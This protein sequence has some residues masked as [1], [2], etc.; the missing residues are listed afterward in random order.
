MKILHDDR[1]Y[2]I[3]LAFLTITGL[4]L[5]FYSIDS[6]SIWLDEAITWNIS[7]LPVPVIWQAVM[8]DNN[9]PLF[10]FIEHIMLQF[11]N[12][13]LIL[14]LIPAIAGSMT[15]PAFY[16]LGKEFHSRGIGV[17]AAALLAFSSYHLF[18]S[19]EARAYSVLLLIFSI[20]LIFYFKAFQTNSLQH[21]MLCGFFSAV[22]CWLH[23]T[24]FPVIIFLFLF[25]VARMVYKEHGGFST[26]KPVIL[27]ATFSLII[28]APMIILA[29]HSL[30]SKLSSPLTW[31]FKGY[32]LITEIFQQFL[33]NIFGKNEIIVVIL[34]LL[35]LIGLYQLYRTDR[36]KFLF[37]FLGIAIPILAGYFLSTKMPTDPRY[38][39]LI[40]P[41][42]FLAI[43]VCLISFQ[44]AIIKPAFPVIALI[45]VIMISIPP[46]LQYYSA[47][48]ECGREK[49]AEDWRGFS[50]ELQ[51]Y[52]HEGDIII[53][54][55]SYYRWPL[56]YYYNN[57]TE[58]TIEFGKSTTKDLENILASN[59]TSRKLFFVLGNIEVNDPTGELISWIKAHTTFIRQNGRISLYGIP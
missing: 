45:I 3:I 40:L 29:I 22:A 39:I 10:Y 9:P 7:G 30:H 57:S 1:K 56:N 53:V 4:I 5:R 12:S 25:A 35:C 17:V 58:N 16:F 55:P 37:F 48:S 41:F 43:S 15:I 38:F 6:N 50:D 2:C 46:L 27:A 51:A 8:N 44:E 13:E 54:I 36:E 34:C 42:L 59:N 24:A 31:G 26:L 11:G 20:S 47:G 18:Y 32:Q 49:C 21:W 33:G 19:Q 23:Y 14:R 52:A 28:V